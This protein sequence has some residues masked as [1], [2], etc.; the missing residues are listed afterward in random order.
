[1]FF[2]ISWPRPAKVSNLGQRCSNRDYEGQIDGIF[3]SIFKILTYFLFQD[4]ERKLEKRDKEFYELK[5]EKDMLVQ[6]AAQNQSQDSME[7]LKFARLFYFLY[8]SFLYFLK[9]FAFKDLLN[10]K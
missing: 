8:F 7:E 1:M 10:E 9:L 6:S 5:A 2:R 4:S 3:N